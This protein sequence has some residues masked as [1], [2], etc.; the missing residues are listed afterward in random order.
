[1]AASDKVFK[2]KKTIWLSYDLGLRGDYSGLYTWL[3][4]KD[5]KECGDSIAVFKVNV[6]GDIVDT[7]TNELKEAVKF[8]A[9]DRVYI[10]YKDKDLNKGKFIIGNRKRSPWEGYGLID[11]GVVQEDY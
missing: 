1:M 5:A 6:T 8:T 11:K 9:T 4:N 2:R 7:I 10:I 3:A